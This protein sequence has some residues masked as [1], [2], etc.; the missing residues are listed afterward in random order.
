MVN[1]VHEI[2]YRTLHDRWRWSVK[3]DIVQKLVREIQM[4]SEV[5]YSTELYT[6]D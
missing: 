5:R 3:L 2:K 1:E 4:V 6:R